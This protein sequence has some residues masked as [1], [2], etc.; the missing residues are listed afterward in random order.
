MGSVLIQ[1]VQKKILQKLAYSLKLASLDRP[2]LSGMFQSAD[3]SEN[4]IFFSHLE[5]KN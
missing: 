5:G 3:V 2:E 1:S 4:A